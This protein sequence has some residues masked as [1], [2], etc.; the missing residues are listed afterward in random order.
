MSKRGGSLNFR[1]FPNVNVDF[2]CFGS[3]KVILGNFKCSIKL[4]FFRRGK[5]DDFPNFNFSPN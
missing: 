4:V 5:I 2:K 3:F 1:V